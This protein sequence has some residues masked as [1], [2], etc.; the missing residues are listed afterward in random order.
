MS[1]IIIFSQIDHE[2]HR[3]CRHLRHRTSHHSRIVVIDTQINECSSSC[4]NA[5]NRRLVIALASQRQLRIA[6]SNSAHS[7]GTRAQQHMLSGQQSLLRTSQHACQMRRQLRNAR[8]GRIEGRRT[9]QFCKYTRAVS[10]APLLCLALSKFATRHCADCC[11]L[12][13]SLCNRDDSARINCLHRRETRA[14]NRARVFT[15][16]PS[17]NAFVTECVRARIQDA[18]RVNAAPANTTL[19]SLVARFLCRASLQSPSWDQ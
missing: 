9:H 15:S 2:R 16:C 10:H 13:C 5:F 17:Q 3:H 11:R 6:R 7:L 19:L 12:L 18:T 8:I 1:L 14:A 4:H